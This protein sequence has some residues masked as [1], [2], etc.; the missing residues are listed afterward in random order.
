MEVRSISIANANWI[1]DSL[2]PPGI[3]YSKH[4][5]S[6]KETWCKVTGFRKWDGGLYAVDKYFVN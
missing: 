5:A 3:K 4:F 1:T 2:V 6:V